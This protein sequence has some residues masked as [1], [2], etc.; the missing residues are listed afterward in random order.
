MKTT[1]QLLGYAN[2]WGVVQIEKLFKY[3]VIY[4]RIDSV[5]FQN[6]SLGT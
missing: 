3:R 2:N 1:P 6:N 4:L 5:S